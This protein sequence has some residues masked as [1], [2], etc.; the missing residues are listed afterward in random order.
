MKPFNLV[1]ASLTFSSK[2]AYLKYMTM[3]YRRGAK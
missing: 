2:A 1:S 3:T